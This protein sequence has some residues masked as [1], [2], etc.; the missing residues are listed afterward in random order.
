[1]ATLQYFMQ[2]VVHLNISFADK[3]FAHCRST[4]LSIIFYSAALTIHP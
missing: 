3:R 2:I 4:S 1:M